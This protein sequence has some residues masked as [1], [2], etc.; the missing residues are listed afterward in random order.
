M[1]MVRNLVGMLDY[2]MPTTS[3]L[4]P[5]TEMDSKTETEFPSGN[6]DTGSK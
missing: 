1:G 4:Q 3:I 5:N 2:G 6:F